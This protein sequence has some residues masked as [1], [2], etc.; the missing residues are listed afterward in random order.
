MSSMTEAQIKDILCTVPAP[1]CGNG[2]VETGEACDDGNQVNTD[3]CS[4]SCTVVPGVDYTGCSV[5]FGGTDLTEYK[6]GYLNAAAKLMNTNFGP[7]GLA[8]TNAIG[9]NITTE[10]LGEKDLVIAGGL[11]A[12][13][14]NQLVS[15]ISPYLASAPDRHLMIVF[16]GS[17][18]YLP[19]K[20]LNQYGVSATGNL[21]LLGKKNVGAKDRA[22]MRP[23]LL[24]ISSMCLTT[25]S[26]LSKGNSGARIS[27]VSQYVCNYEGVD[28]RGCLWSEIKLK[29]GSSIHIITSVGMLGGHPTSQC[30][31]N[32]NYVVDLQKKI[33]NFAC[34]DEAPKPVCGNSK[35]ET[36]EACDD[37]NTANGD[38]CSDKCLITTQCSDGV[39][40]SDPEDTL[41]DCTPGASDP[42]CFPNGIGG[43][44]NCDPTDNDETNIV[45][46][47]GNNK[48]EGAEKC[49]DGN[50]TNGDGCSNY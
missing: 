15:V 19:N 6:D 47:C 40:N 17:Q 36:G 27:E 30:G 24:G 33:L 34:V 48:L 32:L 29:S 39:D 8:V 1:V 44:G 14:D 11:S 9:T 37:G 26:G 5:Y 20:F 45:P 23:E 2:F 35:L 10:V 50:T 13:T 25:P 22:N 3:L 49:D 43:G 12:N 41:V 16:D 28:E 42:G 21:S 38:G 4:N 7:K 31:T 46:V 18:F